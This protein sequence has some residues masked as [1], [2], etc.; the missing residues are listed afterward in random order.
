MKAMNED[1]A[2][3]YWNYC[4]AIGSTVRELTGFETQML[5]A[6]VDPVPGMT[7][8][9]IGCGRADVAARLA[10]WG[11]DVHAVD[12]SPGMLESALVRHAEVKGLRFH[13]HDI[14]EV[15]G[16]AGLPW[17]EPGSLDLVV[18][19][20]SLDFMDLDLLLANVRHWLRPEG[21]MHVTTNVRE[22][23]PPDEPP[24][25]LREEAIDG[26]SRQWR[27]STRYDLENDGSVTC[28]VLRGPS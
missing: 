9:D 3:D 4:Y 17:L 22:R 21:V 8:L 16:D 15:T 26:L 18:C 25:G 13:L 1:R 7:A 6:Y 14:D 19:R 5:R 12:F 11:L 27:S 24:R 10:T 28:L 23:M 2:R 20:L